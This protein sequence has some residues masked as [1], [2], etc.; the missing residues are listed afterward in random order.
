[1]VLAQCAQGPGF[2]PHHGKNKNTIEEYFYQSG[3]RFSDHIR[4]AFS[5]IDDIKKEKQCEDQAVETLLIIWEKVLA[6]KRTP[7]TE[8]NN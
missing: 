3:E 4:H 7:Y 6:R 8:M 1:M 2:D 5:S